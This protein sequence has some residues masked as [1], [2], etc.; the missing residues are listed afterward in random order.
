METR[1]G[2]RVIFTTILPVVRVIGSEL[3]FT[4][5]PVPTAQDLAG[6]TTSVLGLDAPPG[7]KS[8]QAISGFTIRTLSW[9]PLLME[10]VTESAVDVT[11]VTF[12][13]LDE[14]EFGVQ[15]CALVP[16]QVKS[17][18]SLTVSLGATPPPR[19][20]PF[21]SAGRR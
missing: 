14:S 18:T 8:I 21:F 3:V 19:P 13:A 10:R 9:S 16:L 15:S 5:T 4:E 12:L 17:C 20:S 11:P 2:A 1:H 6:S 7:R